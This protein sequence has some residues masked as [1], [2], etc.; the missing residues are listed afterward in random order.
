MI[1]WSRLDTEVLV[2]L[3]PTLTNDLGGIVIVVKL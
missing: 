2:A 1:R 3:F